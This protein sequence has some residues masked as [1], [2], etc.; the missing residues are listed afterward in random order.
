MKK[1]TL[2]LLLFCG[3][4]VFAQDYSTSS[5][6]AIRLFE[7]A[8]DYFKQKND[9]QAE[10]LL[11]KAVE[12]DKNFVEPWLMLA[13]IYLDKKDIEKASNFYLN[14]ISIDADSY[15]NGFLKV[16]EM[17]FSIGKY[18]ESQIHLDTWKSYGY[19]SERALALADKLTRNLLYSIYAIEHPVPFNPQS[20]GAAVNTEQYEYW[21]SLSIDEQTIFFTVLGPPNPNLPPE[22]LQMQEDFYYCQNVNNQWVNRTYLGA[23]VNTNTNEGAQTVTADG[24]YIYFTACNRSDGHG[25]MCDLY[26]SQVQED[27]YWSD[28]INLG[29]VVNTNSSEKHP[30]I[31]ADGRILYFTSN[32]AGGHGDYDIWMT[33]QNGNSWSKPINLGDSINTSGMEQS[34]FIH[35]DQQ[36]LYFSSNGWPGLGKGD[37]FLS[38]LKDDGTWAEPMNLGFPINSFNEEVGLIVN[39]KGTRAYYST[40][41]REGTDTDIYA[42]D[43]P[44]KTRPVPVSYVS[45]RVFDS[46]NYKGIKARFQLI[47]LETGRLIM[48]SNSNGGEG[49]Y[50]IGLPS[51]SS[52]AFNVSQKGYLFYSDHFEIEKEY[53]K[54]K[55]LRKDIPLDP[56][57]QGK[58]VVLNNIFYDTESYTLKDESKVELNKVLEFME[59][60]KNIRVEIT[61]HTYNTGSVSF[62]M[63]LSEKRASQVVDY[64]ISRGVSP[65]RIIAKGY[66]ATI[67]VADNNTEEGKAK[68]RRTEL[69]VL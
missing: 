14:G 32:R 69:K 35:P 39:A 25:R 18:Y 47:N 42:F 65:E 36:S 31:S 53:S 29:D 33:V 9:A 64:L 37:I 45:G 58:M 67:S 43:M 61:G 2:I 55:P 20:L 3:V 26:Y 7:Q 40:N 52:Y 15:G 56:I 57:Q 50:F 28:P 23:P 59:L 34:P 63:D 13:Q 12:A 41:R 22:K 27:G 49:D 21:P 68:N 8:Q 17:E 38:R 19:S 51:G 30:A 62:N 1:L 24:K 5:K 11:L 46:R 44:E 6:K 4:T 66:G 54:L 48:E 10:G 16:A 60:N